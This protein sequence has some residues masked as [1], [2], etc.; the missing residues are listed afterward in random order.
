M[1]LEQIAELS[2]NELRKEWDEHIEPLSNEKKERL[3]RQVE[4]DCYDR[5][6]C[7][8]N[9]INYNRIKNLDVWRLTIYEYY[10]HIA[11]FELC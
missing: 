8:N 7:K 2:F 10:R 6:F 9:T 11:F 1:E 3:D 4:S 5:K